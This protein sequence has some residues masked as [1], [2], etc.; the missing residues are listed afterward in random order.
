MFCTD[1]LCHLVVCQVCDLGYIYA[2]LLTMSPS[3]SI[4]Q[5]YETPA[6]IIQCLK[7]AISPKMARVVQWKTNCGSS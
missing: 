4:L 5:S 6:D 3:S 7:S 1:A 2:L